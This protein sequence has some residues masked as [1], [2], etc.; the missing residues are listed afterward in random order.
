MGLLILAGNSGI[1]SINVNSICPLFH[2][3]A[4]ILVSFFCLFPSPLAQTYN[5]LCDNVFMGVML[6]HSK[7][8]YIFFF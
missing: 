7:H 2:Y 3:N 4:K 8:I 1:M 6:W 5:K